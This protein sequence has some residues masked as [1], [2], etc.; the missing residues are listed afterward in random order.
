MRRASLSVRIHLGLG[1]NLGDRSAHLRDAARDLATA[2][3]QPLRRSPWYE[4]AYVGP[5][6]PQPP[7]WN[8]VLE[9]STSL[10]PLELLQVL[11]G[12]EA[13]HGRRPGTHLQPRPLDLDILLYA[14]W[15]VRHPRLVVPHPRL[16]ER[17]FVLQPL[18][19]LGCLD[20]R[21]QLRA[22]LEALSRE[23]TLRR[24]EAELPGGRRAIAC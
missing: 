24:V 5:G 22:R 12:I 7:Y 8:A 21:P 4:S 19:D 16:A 11:Q 18:D 15:T 23:Q 14:G 17:R 6:A 2:G 10:R 9:A 3:V 20:G 13:R 1:S